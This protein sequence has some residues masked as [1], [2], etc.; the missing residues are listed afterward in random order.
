MQVNK[1]VEVLT[2]ASQSFI[3]STSKTKQKL[4]H[5]KK[6]TYFKQKDTVL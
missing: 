1:R 4:N 2:G 3:K 5:L 6:K